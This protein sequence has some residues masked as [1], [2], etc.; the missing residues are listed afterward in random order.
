[1]TPGMS[2]GKSIGYLLAAAIALAAGPAGAGTWTIQAE[3]DRLA[4][5]DRHYTHGHRASWVSDEISDLPDWAGEIL[6]RAYPLANVRRGRIGAALGQ[7]IYTPEDTESYDLIADDRPYA[8]WLYGSIAVHAETEQNLFG[9][10]ARTLDTVEL[11]IGIVGPWAFGRQ[12]QNKFHDLIGV[13]RSNGWGHQLRNEP[14][15]MLV[16]E[17]RWRSPAY[18]PGPIAIDFIPHIGGSI[19][20]VMTHANTGLVLRIGQNL[21]V[22]FG[23]AHIRPSLSAPPVITEG[24]AEWGWYLFAGGEARLVAHN[25]FLDG[26]TFADSHSVDRKPL[27]ADAQAGFAIVGRSWRFTFAHIFRT[28]EFDGQRRADRFSAVSLSK[29]F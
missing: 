12:V 21:D 16:G 19:G 22:D 6:G 24:A 9:N 2:P 1:M 29:R 17:H 15:I 28:R 18:D 11:N 8:G 23:P 27:V 7:S 26:N 13:G 25:I 5:T 10:E 20:N 3:N 14:G 4:D